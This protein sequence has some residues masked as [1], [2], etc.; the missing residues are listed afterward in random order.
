MWNHIRLIVLAIFIGMSAMTVA[1]CKKGEDKAQAEAVKARKEADEQA[2]EAA[3]RAREA[4]DRVA[5]MQK[6]LDD[7]AMKASAEARATYQKELASK[8]GQRVRESG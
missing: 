1:A 2:A 6:E 4:Q 5:A 3:R 8:S 7:K